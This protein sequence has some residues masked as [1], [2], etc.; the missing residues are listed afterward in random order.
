ML[1]RPA[2]FQLTAVKP[3]FTKQPRQKELK[4][5]KKP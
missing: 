4:V 3:Y 2:K 1:Q 5:L